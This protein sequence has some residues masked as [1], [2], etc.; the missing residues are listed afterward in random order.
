MPCK[1]PKVATESLPKLSDPVPLASKVLDCKARLLVNSSVPL[2]SS[3]MPV[4]VFEPPRVS[5]PPPV[6]V[7]P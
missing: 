6:A 7:R 5:V 1:P 2:L 3:V 4:K